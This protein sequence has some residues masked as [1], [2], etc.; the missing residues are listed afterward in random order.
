MTAFGFDTGLTREQ[1]AFRAGGLE[2]AAK[3]KEGTRSSDVTAFSS[4]KKRKSIEKKSCSENVT[5]KNRDTIHVPR[6]QMDRSSSQRLNPS[7]CVEAG[8]SNQHSG[9]SMRH[10]HGTPNQQQITYEYSF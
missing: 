6:R 10:I 8:I 4:S 9:N 2:I 3:V 1:D 5:S 7:F